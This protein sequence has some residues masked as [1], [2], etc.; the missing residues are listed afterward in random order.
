MYIVR[1]KKRKGL[2]RFVAGGG[3]GVEGNALS[4]FRVCACVCMCN[5]MSSHLI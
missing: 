4:Y 1:K 2:G 3:G 5:M